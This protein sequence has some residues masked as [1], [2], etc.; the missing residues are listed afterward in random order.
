MEGMDE[1]LSFWQDKFQGKK[2]GDNV[3]FDNHIG[4]GKLMSIILNDAIYCLSFDIKLKEDFI[5][6]GVHLVDDREY[7]SFLY[8]QSDAADKRFLEFDYKET[9]KLDGV[10]VSNDKNGMEWYIPKETSI[11][12][13]LI[14]VAPSYVASMSQ[15]SEFLEKKFPTDK[16]FITFDTLDSIMSGV[17]LRLFEI[18]D[19]LFE[20]ELKK[21]CINY[22]LTLTF[23]QFTKRSKNETKVSTDLKALF[24]ARQ[25]II[26]EYGN[27]NTIE[28]LA[29][30]VGLSV[31]KLRLLF[32][33][34][35]GISIYKFQQQVRLDE[36]K[37][38]LLDSDKTMSMIAMD[39]GFATA[40][41]F[42]S[43]FKKHFGYLP[44]EYR[45]QKKK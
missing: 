8:G 23:S 5:G 21:A 18:E 1:L 33:T 24:Y 39:L 14:K 16:P 3:S 37:N 27:I 11:K 26:Q 13:L 45:L 29:L 17:L 19:D 36:A 25:I 9:V 2:N 30:E 31:S 35:F 41:H 42:T 32:K 38:L 15:R 43:V 10:I 34:T 28:L 7:I 12:L 40:S 4:K 22:L 20:V 6:E 44:K